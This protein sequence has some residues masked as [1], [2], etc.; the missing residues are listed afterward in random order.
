MIIE[1]KY[2]VGDQV[3]AAHCAWGTK[4]VTCEDCDGKGE[5]Q[6]EGKPFDLLCPTCAGPWNEKR[7][8]R[9]MPER[10][11][12]VQPLTIGMVRVQRGYEDK[13]EY[14]CRETGVGSGG[15]WREEDLLPTLEAAEARAAEKVAEQIAMAMREE[16]DKRSR[17]HRSRPTRAK[18]V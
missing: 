11:P 18:A 5:L 10:K 12:E 7:G 2:S 14:M 1:T 4:R 8:W 3:Y 17:K 13:N 15:I 9:E 6:V 16:E